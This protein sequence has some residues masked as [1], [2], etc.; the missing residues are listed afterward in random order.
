MDSVLLTSTPIYIGRWTMNQTVLV[1]KQRNY[2][3]DVYYPVNTL[4]NMVTDLVG[5]KT[6]TEASIRVLKNYGY[7]VQ[8][9]A[10]PETL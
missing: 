6:I 2:G 5:S 4:A 7:T 10:K 3:Q 8:V 9:D 1:R